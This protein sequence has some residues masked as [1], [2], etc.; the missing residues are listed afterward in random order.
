MT[1]A[2]GVRPA[3]NRARAACGRGRRTHVVLP[4][5]RS[6]ESGRRVV[7]RRAEHALMSRLATTYGKTWR[8]WNTERDA[9][10]LG[11]PALM[12]AFTADGQLRCGLLEDRDR[13]FGI[14]TAE[15]RRERRDIA[16]PPRL[17]G[18]D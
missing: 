8:L 5:G 18:D 6:H 14:S 15:R 2:P 16:A 1:R 4:E 7:P 10:P 17:S 13:R 12:M 11:T 3:S 9:L